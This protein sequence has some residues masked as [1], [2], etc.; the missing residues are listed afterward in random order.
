MIAE[1]E[2]AEIPTFFAARG[3]NTGPPATGTGHPV[4]FLTPAE[5][6]CYG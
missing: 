4:L 1:Q 2:A 5:R 6:A 3:E